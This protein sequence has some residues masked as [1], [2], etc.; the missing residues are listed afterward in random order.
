MRTHD[1][2]LN[3]YIKQ[4]QKNFWLTLETEE[5]EKPAD[6]TGSA[7]SEPTTFDTDVQRSTTR[8]LRDL[9]HH[10]INYLNESRPDISFFSL[11]MSGRGRRSGGQ[12][13]FRRNLK[14][15]ETLTRRK[16][17]PVFCFGYMTSSK[18]C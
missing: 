18:K 14:L 4:L 8:A 5:E 16:K 11:E 17:I 9:Q 6:I 15:G 3:H 1:P 13:P 2:R 12:I 10:F 7:R